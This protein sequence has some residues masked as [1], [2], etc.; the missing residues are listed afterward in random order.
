MSLPL[1]NKHLFFVDPVTDPGKKSKAG[2]LALVKADG[3]FST[4]TQQEA[5]TRGQED[6]MYVVFE[7]GD[8]KKDWTL[9]EVRAR[10][11]KNATKS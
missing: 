6:E 8:L 4:I 11:W 5:V 2:R 3:Q 10:A 7:N 9:R 1:K